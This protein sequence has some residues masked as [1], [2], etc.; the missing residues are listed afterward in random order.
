MH[1]AAAQAG[2][3]VLEQVQLAGLLDPR[4]AEGGSRAAAPPQADVALARAAAAV[5]AG[6]EGVEGRIGH[7]RCTSV[8][9]TA[10]S[11]ESSAMSRR[12]RAAVSQSVITRERRVIDGSCSRW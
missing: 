12:N 6:V 11:A 4:G 7:P 5:V 8:A 2:A 10:L 1:A 3:H 9:P